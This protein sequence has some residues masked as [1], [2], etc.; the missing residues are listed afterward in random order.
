M[1]IVG[2]IGEWMVEKGYIGENGAIG[3]NRR[4]DDDREKLV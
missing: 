3:V 1:V 2:F 4:E